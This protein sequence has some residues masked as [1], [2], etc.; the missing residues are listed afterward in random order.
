MK[1]MLITKSD[2]QKSWSLTFAFVG[3]VVVTIWL[4]LSIFPTIGGLAIRPFSGSD[5]ML[6]LLP[7]LGNYFG[8]KALNKNVIPTSTAPTTESDP[9]EHS[10]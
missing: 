10:A 5:A 1:R 7:I 6:Y 4:T 8:S 2:G 3:F 9:T